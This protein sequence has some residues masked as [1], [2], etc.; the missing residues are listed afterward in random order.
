MQRNVEAAEGGAGVKR[1]VGAM[2]GTPSEKVKESGVFQR[3]PPGKL[4]QFSVG[5]THPFPFLFLGRAAFWVYH[6]L[7]ATFLKSRLVDP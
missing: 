4:P 5:S 2:E 7:A 1:S 6:D 3:V